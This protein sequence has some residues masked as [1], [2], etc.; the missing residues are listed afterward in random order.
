MFSTG[1]QRCKAEL[2]GF[3]KYNTKQILANL[4]ARVLSIIYS[5]FIM[6]CGNIADQLC[7]NDTETS[8]Q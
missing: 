3:W 1:V 7:Y 6:N 8:G 2:N 5:T 4:S